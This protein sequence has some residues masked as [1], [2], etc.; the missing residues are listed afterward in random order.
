V[1]VPGLNDV[2]QI[3]AGGDTCYALKGD[4]SVWAWGDDGFGELGNGTVRLYDAMPQRVHGLENVASIAAGASSAYVLLTDGTVWAWGKGTGGELGDG[5]T[6]DESLPVRVDH[7]SDV[8]Q[9]TANGG[10]AF[11]LDENGVLWSWGNNSYG[12]LGD[13]STTSS[14]VPVRMVDL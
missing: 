2:V 6:S 14:S 7:L 10:E 3:A 8:A 12:Q 1:R 11:A 9:L 13:G 4:G 5:R